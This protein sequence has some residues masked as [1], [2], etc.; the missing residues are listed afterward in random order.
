[1]QES[2]MQALG[3]QNAMIANSCGREQEKISLRRRVAPSSYNL[4]ERFGRCNI[5]RPILSY[6]EQCKPYSDC[7]SQGA[8]NRRKRE[9]V[10]VGYVML[11]YMVI[12][13]APLTG[14]YSE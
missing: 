2:R 13:K 5:G 10:C 4:E 9:S 1:M 7:T 11:C 6:T 14:G 3:L 12:C 8:S